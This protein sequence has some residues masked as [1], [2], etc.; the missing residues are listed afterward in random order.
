MKLLVSL[1]LMRKD[2]NMD[3]DDSDEEIEMKIAMASSVV[4]NYLKVPLTFYD[5]SSGS[6]P[7]DA[8]GEPD[9]PFEVRAATML[10]VREFFSDDPKRGLMEHGYLPRPV[11]ALLYPL[12]DPA[13]G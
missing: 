12:R 11:M 6:I 10:M 13:L 4:L 8:N 9:V 2:L 1:E 5:D 3:H 7:T